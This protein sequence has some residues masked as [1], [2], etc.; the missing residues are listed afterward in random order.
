ML[1]DREPAADPAPRLPSLLGIGDAARL[2]LSRAWASRPGADHLRVP[3]GVDPAGAPVL[4]DL[5][6]QTLAGMGPHGLLVGAV[7][8]AELLRSLLV[9]LAL[10][11][12]PAALN[13]L[14]VHKWRTAGLLGL[15]RLP[16]V[17]V[18]VG[19]LDEP[20]QLDRLA[21][22]VAGELARRRELLRTGGCDSQHDYER[23]RER[24]EPLPPLPRL[25]VVVDDLTDLRSR[26]PD[27]VDLLLD[28]CRVGSALGIHLLLTSEHLA[29][30]DLRDLDA[31]LSYRIALRTLTEKDSRMVLGVPDAYQLPMDYGQ[32]YL[33][34]PAGT[35]T[36]FRLAEV[37][38][39][40]HPPDAG[41][42]V[43]CLPDPPDSERSTLDVLLACM[44]NEG[45]R[46]HQVVLPPLAAPSTLDMLLPA[47]VN[48]AV[49]GLTVQDPGL[50]GG[51]RAVV[52]VVDR[53]F[54][55][56][57]DPLWL[58]LSGDAG[59]LVVIGAPCTGKT[60]LL[61]TLI[62]CLALTHTPR[63]AQFYCLDLGRDELNDLRALPHVGE[64][65]HWRDSV[66]ILRTVHQLHGLLRQRQAR[67]AALGVDSIATYRRMLRDGS[68]PDDPYGDVFLVVD[69]WY[70][71][72][73][74]FEELV[75]LVGEL[76]R[77]GLAVGIHTLATGVRWQ[78][79]RAWLRPAFGTRIELTL[80]EPSDSVIDPGEAGK[81]PSAQPGHGLTPDGHHF[82]TALPRIDGEHRTDD[83]PAALRRLIG[84]VAQAWPE[85]PAPR[86]TPL[87]FH[88]PYE[89]LPEPQPGARLPIAVAAAD[90]QPVLL[91]LDS[92]PHL[93]LFGDAECGK[94]SFL[95]GLAR[96][97]TRAYQPS[98]ARIIL[99][100]YHRATR[101]CVTTE[102]LIGFGASG[103]ATDEIIQQVVTA[104]RARLPGP[105][106]GPEL[107]PQQR[108]ERGWW[109]GPRLFVL[110]DD[111][112]LV[113]AGA[114]NP[115]LP[116]VELLPHGADIG[117]HV[118]ITR[119]IA[120]AARAMYDPV[121]R[122]I[123]DLGPARVVMSGPG[124]ERI[125]DITPQ[126]LPPGRG[127]LSTRR[128]GRRLVQFP[129]V[130]PAP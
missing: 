70:R 56:R 119:R 22:G 7:G 111:Y 36:R 50:W 68:V 11:H 90:L 102:H 62:A 74:E 63:E 125:H 16:H 45:P 103:P 21:A 18:L 38:Y 34:G 41:V 118:V 95:R 104:M 108:R 89:A 128:E 24:G 120:G 69:N 76:A 39:P 44:E 92:Q 12:S 6:D 8:T 46:A 101:G 52:G 3:I 97:I 53:P 109:R 116:L 59:N 126:L 43:I 33:R 55:Q 99:I 60:T 10:T 107:S 27:L 123:N 84:A 29:A 17:S 122:L 15:D 73:A 106:L 4:L 91:D 26:R 100:D 54:E 25:L 75:P 30:D 51:M 57:R 112:D 82:L 32:A 9:G 98:E 14:W 61:R 49:R 77:D 5:K 83:L 115:L 121:L 127:W 113:A 67:F 79:L 105:E 81:L 23:A 2:D 86:V 19:H 71:L 37:S 129:W 72:Q 35:L 110:I 87:P 80:G 31:H 1:I 48:D 13:I 117:L 124:Q 40:Y 96:G 64:V 42:D 85:R 114:S 78:E 93:L 65:T 88:L 130:P 58:D 66:G 94:S 20:I 28:T 47:L